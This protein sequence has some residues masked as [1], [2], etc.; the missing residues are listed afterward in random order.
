MKYAQTATP[1]HTLA[2]LNAAVA[3]GA[4]I[5]FTACADEYDLP[6]HD[7]PRSRGWTFAGRASMW[8]DSLPGAVSSDAG[9]RNFESGE[10]R[11]RAFYPV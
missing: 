8:N 5:E 7:Q 10:F 6:P 3:A 11:L 2:D 4:L 1:I 9:L